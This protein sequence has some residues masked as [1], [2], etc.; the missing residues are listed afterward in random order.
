M[1][2]VGYDFDELDAV[3]VI[4]LIEDEGLYKSQVVVDV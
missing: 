2:V 4:D 3:G 1:V